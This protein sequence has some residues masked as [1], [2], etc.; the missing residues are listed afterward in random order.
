MTVGEAV[1]AS[2]R[3]DEEYLGRLQI[4]DR[5][6]AKIAARAAR[7]V[8]EAGSAAPRVLG[9]TLPWSGRLGTRDSDL[10]APPKAAVEVEGSVSRIELSIGVRWP[11]SIPDVAEWVRDQVRTRVSHLT[12]LRV[13]EVEI[14]VDDLILNQAPRARVR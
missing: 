6:V 8:A 3:P 13:Q 14:T 7:E 10:D 5:V 2:G 9:R 11:A 12:G 1:D 4:H